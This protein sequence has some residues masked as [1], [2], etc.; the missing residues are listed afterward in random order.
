MHAVVS[1]W[2]KAP[3]APE[4]KA[5]CSF[6]ARLTHRPTEAREQDLDQLRDLGFDDQAI[7]DATQVVGFF[8]YITR[9]AEALGVEAEK[10]VPL[11]GLPTGTG[12]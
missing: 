9:I 7:H 2:R 3:L 8:N 1:D 10:F 6:A 11:W 4:D 12:T 5:L